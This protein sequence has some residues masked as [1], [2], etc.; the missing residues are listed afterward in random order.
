MG[1]LGS[2]HYRGGHVI[3]VGYPN[4]KIK[5]YPGI[6]FQGYIFECLYLYEGAL[7]PIPI[8]KILH[9]K[10]KVKMD[11]RPSN[12]E[13]ITNEQNIKLTRKSPRV[14][15]LNPRPWVYLGSL[16]KRQQKYPW[17]KDN[18][19]IINGYVMVY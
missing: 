3:R 6:Y 1:G 13:V 10:N 5:N 19:K 2:G 11:S 4:I 8:N 9:H 12:I 7:G 17:L 15:R 16:K 18:E 14:R